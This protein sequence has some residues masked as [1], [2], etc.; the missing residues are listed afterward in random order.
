MRSLAEAQK[1]RDE[2]AANTIIATV[3][4]HRGGKKNLRGAAV[5]ALF[6][7]A[8]DEEKLNVAAALCCDVPHD[9]FLSH[10][11]V[12]GNLMARVFVMIDEYRNSNR[13]R[14][15]I[16]DDDLE[17][18]KYMFAN[19][20][21][22]TFKDWVVYQSRGFLYD[23][24][25]YVRPSA[26]KSYRKTVNLAGEQVFVVS[27]WRVDEHG[28]DGNDGEEVEWLDFDFRR[29]VLQPR[30]PPSRVCRNHRGTLHE[31]SAY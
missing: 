4:I 7:E 22:I 21:T 28:N 14:N 2:S 29:D 16:T 23:M 19:D 5:A 30:W 25:Q 6:A 8:S 31:W 17:F 3:P 12:T 24:F 10:T 20:C 27:N 1:L 26:W 15:L 18:L 9:T 11:L 13:T